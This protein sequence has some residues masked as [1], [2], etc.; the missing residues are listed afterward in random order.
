MWVLVAQ[1]Y[2]LGNTIISLQ[3]NPFT[4][5][6]SSL[7]NKCTSRSA[8]W[9]AT[10]SVLINNQ[11]TEFTTWNHLI[12]V[13]TTHSVGC[14]NKGIIICKCYVPHFCCQNKSKL[15]TSCISVE[16]V[17]V[18][19]DFR[20]W[21]G[22]SLFELCNCSPKHLAYT[23]NIYKMPKCLGCVNVV[24]WTAPFQMQ[25]HSTTIY[26]QLAIVY[27]YEKECRLIQH[28]SNKSYVHEGQNIQYS[29]L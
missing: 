14:E 13:F 6:K 15:H 11:A 12:T 7:K 28:P 18:V 1:L 10:T 20:C 29:L 27:T 8:M 21:Y 5:A 26:S 4:R 2:A 9:Q 24:T 16:F 22:L 23:F 3:L 17:I 25:F 19:P